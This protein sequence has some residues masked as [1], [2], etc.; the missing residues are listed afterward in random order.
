MI[1]QSHG[2]TLSVLFACRDNAGLS[3][4]AEALA[5]RRAPRIKAF[6]GGLKPAPVDLTA[7]ECLHAARIPADGLSSKP[8]E[9]F[10][11][12]GAPRI[13]L[14]VS[15]VEDVEGEVDH[16]ARRMHCDHRRWRLTD[17]AALSDPHARRLAYRQIL[18]DLG[19][20][21]GGLLRETASAA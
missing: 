3:L 6:S 2:R 16:L 13:D 9:V 20:A 4:V 1:E 11:Q 17:A 21:I 7:V 15:L 5:H 8:L 18:P 12:P 14:V 10:A 19:P